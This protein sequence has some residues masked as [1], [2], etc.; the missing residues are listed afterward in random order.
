MSSLPP[1]T[2]KPDEDPA[3]ELARLMKIPGALEAYHGYMH[4]FHG[5]P[6]EGCDMTDLGPHEGPAFEAGLERGRCGAVESGLP[7]CSSSVAGQAHNLEVGGS[8]PL[9]GTLEDPRLG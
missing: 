2:G 4:G 9:P 7:G 6:Y 3:A 8:N 5:F 1:D